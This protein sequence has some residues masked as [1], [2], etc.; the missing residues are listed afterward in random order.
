MEDVNKTIRMSGDSIAEN[1]NRFCEEIDNTAL[2]KNEE[3][4]LQR[5]K[6]MGIA[7]IHLKRQ[8]MM[9]DFIDELTKYLV[10][11][12]L[13]AFC[14]NDGRDYKAIAYSKPYQEEMY[15]IFMGSNQHGLLE[16]INVVFFD[17]MDYMLE[18]LKKLLHQLK[19]KN[20]EILEQQCETTFY[21][22]FI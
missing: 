13:F 20:V 10:L 7:T 3:I 17:S 11:D 9:E 5:S 15:V 22:N 1:F 6:K 14:Q 18:I 19:N 21:K 8:M 16:E 12:V 2:F 4:A